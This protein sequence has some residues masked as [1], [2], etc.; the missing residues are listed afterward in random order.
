MC[1]IAKDAG[2]YHCFSSS[3]SAE[4]TSLKITAATF[5]QCNSIPNTNTWFTSKPFDLFHKICSSYNDSN[6]TAV[7]TSLF[8]INIGKDIEP[9]YEVYEASLSF[10]STLKDKRSHLAVLQKIYMMHGTTRDMCSTMK[11]YMLAE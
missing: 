3:S 11:N 4:S 10:R 2:S 7:D 9:Y 6:Y 1:L 8:Q 5:T